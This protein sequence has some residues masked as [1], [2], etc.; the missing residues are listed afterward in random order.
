V[1]LGSRLGR[2]DTKDG[3]CWDD[4]VIAREDK[5]A[6]GPG[7]PHVST[8]MRFTSGTSSP[9]HVRVAGGL[10]RFHRGLGPLVGIYDAGRVG[11]VGYGDDG[12]R[13]DLPINR[14][15]ALQQIQFMKQ[16][17]W[18]DR[19]ACARMHSRGV[20]RPRAKP[21]VWYVLWTVPRATGTRAV[22]LDFNLYN[23]NTRLLSVVHIVVEFFPQSFVAHI[24]RFYS[25]KIL[26]YSAFWDQVPSGYARC[27]DA[28]GDGGDSCG[29]ACRS[30]S[31]PRSC[32][33]SC[34]STT[35]RRSFDA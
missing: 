19:G 30:D 13:V 23:T 20:F 34:G 29:A 21:V 8:S 10:W 14:D 18:I 28:R 31:S 9:L 16:H 17:M 5:E 25:F 7:T 26:Y 3:S 12:Y 15:A 27:C 11:A 33:C 32:T 35:S 22:A 1:A 2:F 6:F 4:F 24:Y